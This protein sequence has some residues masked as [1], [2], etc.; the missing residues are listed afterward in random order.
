[1]HYLHVALSETLRLYPP[2]PLNV[3]EL[4]EDNLILP[5]GRVLKKGTVVLQA[6]YSM[7]RMEKIW[8]KYCREFKP[9]RWLQDGVFTSQDGFKFPVFSAR[10]RVC[11]GKDFAY[12]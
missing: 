6:I 11:L 5:G 9:E 7:G 8:G 3:K 4:A 10:P 2:V 1:M 12:L